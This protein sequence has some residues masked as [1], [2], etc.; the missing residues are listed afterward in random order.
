ME[1][2]R[3]FLALFLFFIA[4]TARADL[5]DIKFGQYQIADSQWNVSACLYT[6]TCQ[7]YSKNPGT[8]YKIPWT[9]GQVQWAAGDYVKFELSGNSSFPYTA[10]QYDSAGN[11]K[12]TLGNGKIVNM[13][14]DYFF[15]VGSDNN[16]GQLF[17]G[18]S[19]MSGTSGV[20]WT[21][22]LNPTIAQANTYADATYSTVPLS[23]GQT[24]TV[25][26]SS[27][28]SAPAPS[29]P[30]SPNTNN[31]NLGFETGTTQNWT[32]S[33]GTGTEKTSGWSSN[34]EGVQTSKGMTN[35]Q[36][37]GGKTWTVTPYG[38]YMMVIQAGGGSPNFDP[39]MTS[40][41]M[42]NTEITAI[43]NYLTSLGGNS[44]PTNASWAKRTV[45]LESGKTYVIAWQ[46]MST[47]YTPFNDGS[48]MTLVH[49][50]DPTKIPVLNNETKRYALLGFTNPGTGN[51]ATDSYGS[52]GW[53]LATIT[54]P[55]NGDYILGFSSFNLGDTALSPI[56]FV[57]DLQGATALNGTTF[58]PIAPNAG[59]SAPSSG[60][61]A[62]PACP[63]NSTCST[64]PFNANSG[65]ANRA[66]VWSQQNGNK[67]IIEQIG[68][69]N[70]TTVQQTGKK[71]YAEVDI[72]GSSNTT[73]IIQ[74]A[75]GTTTT[76]YLELTISGNNNTINLNQSGTAGAKGILATVN[77]A[78]NSLTVN[79][80]GTGN[81]YAEISVSGGNKTV[82]VT[83]SGSAGHMANI[84]LT[85]GA[86]A[87]TTTQTGSTQQ[88]YSINHNC[89]Q[90]SC[91]AITVT[92]G[93]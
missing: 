51:Y 80:S 75:S 4:A 83:Q 57:D 50:S 74:N 69:Y 85:G 58:G 32:I 64:D 33:N 29:G 60:G 13:G 27:Q 14:P 43:R 39:A 88:N 17:S 25:T 15:F 3:I 23:S 48:I 1:Q 21:G 38:T 22:T 2:M 86:T 92:Q 82:N 77:N 52:T 30:V 44:T 12:T 16:T 70:I 8:A 18:S 63:N 67:V 45:A 79:Q 19:G 35:Y 28:Q 41:G 42:T 56:L 68:N 72:T 6:D 10:K 46:Y 84:T 65:F 11:V 81:H 55:V 26:P 49:A 53:Q 37:G 87:I 61:P 76:N 59:S 47:D 89:A 34:G 93:Q 66:N 9:S 24:A 5:T 7:I 62:A 36:P 54:V 73:N 90:A 71:N 91:A 40:L 31:A 78:S 20:S